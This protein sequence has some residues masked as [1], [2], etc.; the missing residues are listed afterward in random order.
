MRYLHILFLFIF[1]FII[2]P[3][4]SDAA[5]TFGWT[6][7]DITGS[8]YAVYGGAFTALSGQDVFS[9]EGWLLRGTFGG[10]EYSFDLDSGEEVDV[11]AYSA[12]VAIGRSLFFNNGSASFYTGIGAVRTERSSIDPGNNFTETDPS[13]RLSADIYLSPLKDTTVL[14]LGSYSTDADAYWTHAA[15]SYNFGPFALGPTVGI[16]GDNDYQQLRFGATI[17]NIDVKFATA[18]INSGYVRDQDNKG[19]G[20]FGMGI[21]RTF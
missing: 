11:V 7:F 5:D 18:H 15:A 19:S 16:A 2:L 4:R 1:A 20:F 3:G 13:L 9:E 14:A 21:G 17:S 10:G 8:S 12:D 6:G